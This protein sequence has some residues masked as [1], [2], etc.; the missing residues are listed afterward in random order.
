MS[1][2]GSS[3]KRE[4]PGAS[5]TSSPPSA[6]AIRVRY[7]ALFATQVVVSSSGSIQHA[8][9]LHGCGITSMLQRADRAAAAS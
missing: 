8:T 4:T 3:P 1:I 6:I 2:T 5:T 7:T 9:R